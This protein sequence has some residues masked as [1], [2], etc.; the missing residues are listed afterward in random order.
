M[1]RRDTVFK[2]N[3]KT[4]K[5]AVK[6]MNKVAERE[7]GDKSL[8]IKNVPRGYYNLKGKCVGSTQ[9]CKPAPHFCG[10]KVA[11]FA[12]TFPE[13]VGQRFRK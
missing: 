5:K 1:L 8:Q 3:G 7:M 11:G 12:G 10:R 6:E 2:P 4:K 9:C 13:R